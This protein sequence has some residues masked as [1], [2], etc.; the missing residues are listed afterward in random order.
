MTDVNGRYLFQGMPSGSDSVIALEGS[1]AFL[2]RQQIRGE[3]LLGSEPQRRGG[4]FR[5]G[6]ELNN[7]L[8][9]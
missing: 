4:L 1:L 7:M 5:M 3:R 9:T 8:F 6:C 2:L